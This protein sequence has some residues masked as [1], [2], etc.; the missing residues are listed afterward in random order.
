MET[1]HKVDTFI[2]KY[3]EQIGLRSFVGTHPNILNAKINNLLPKD[4]PYHEIKF[5][6]GATWLVN[7]QTVGHEIFYGNKM[8]AYTYK[9]DPTTLR[10]PE[11]DFL[12][13][14]RRAMA[15]LVDRRPK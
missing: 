15:R 12:T 7:S 11:G 9:V 10:N 13:R 3:G 4:L 6:P 8:L 1:T 2:D 14:S 5:A